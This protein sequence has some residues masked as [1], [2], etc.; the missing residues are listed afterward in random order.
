LS[1]A[2][3]A[4]RFPHARIVGVELD[5]ENTLLARTNVAPWSDRCEIHT[6]AVWTEDRELTYTATR[7]QEWCLRIDE[8]ER[9]SSRVR[10]ISLNTLLHQG[11]SGGVDF[12][13]MDIEGAEREVLTRQTGWAE[14]VRFIAVEVHEPYEVEACERDLSALGFATRVDDGWVLGERTVTATLPR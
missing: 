6:A 3:Y 8:A 11:Q 4:V 2:Q 9:G 14:Q 12:C 10:G 13:V 1:V 5:D 7:G